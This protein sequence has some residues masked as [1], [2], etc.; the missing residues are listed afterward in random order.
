MKQYIAITIVITLFINANDKQRV[1]GELAHPAPP[2]D[3]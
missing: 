3:P 1:V 2:R